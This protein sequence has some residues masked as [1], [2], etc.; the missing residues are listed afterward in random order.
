MEKT[1][2]VLIAETRKKIVDAIN[3]SQLHPAIISLILGNISA[4]VQ[5]L[6]IQAEK[7][8]CHGSASDKA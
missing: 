1:I 4:Q 3:E 8:D 6:E 2:S 5:A 7:G